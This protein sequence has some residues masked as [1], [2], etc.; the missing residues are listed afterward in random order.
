MGID[1]LSKVVV[2][3]YRYGML[4]L[5]LG[6]LAHHIHWH[7]TLPPGYSYDPY[8]SYVCALMLLLNHLAFAFKWPR[9]VNIA[10]WV[11]AWSWLIFGLFYICYLSRVLYPLE[12]VV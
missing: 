8:A 6:V 1:K 7:V 4:A 9:R 12:R 3:S 11:L 10:M 2:S 5:I